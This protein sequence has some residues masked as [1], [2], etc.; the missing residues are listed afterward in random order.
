MGNITKLNNILCY[1]INAIDGTVASDIV[2][3]DAN[4]FCVSPT[5]TPTPS[6]TPT[7]TPTPGGVTPT[8]TPTP[9]PEC[10]G[11]CC[12]AELC[13]GGDCSAACSC[14]RSGLFYLSVCNEGTPCYLENA[15]GIY[16]ESRCGDPAP[17]NYYADQSGCYYWDGSA[18]SY[19]GPC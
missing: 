15:S 7:P 17:E 5:P 10:T 1:D 2:K 6:V 9:S 4:E 8:P 14:T 13:Y 3:W 16:T 18:L 11:F 12:E 19:Q